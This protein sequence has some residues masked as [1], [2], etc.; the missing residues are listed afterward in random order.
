MRD[1]RS[2]LCVLGGEI[3]IILSVSFFFCLCH[4]P[5]A[6]DRGTYTDIRVIRVIKVIRVIR[7]Y[8]GLLWVI[9][10]IRIIRVV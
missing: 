10:V 4:C 9:R 7:G 1:R 6:V 5:S 2:D 3:M 8:K